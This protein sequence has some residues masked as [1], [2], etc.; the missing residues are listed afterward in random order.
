MKS[1]SASRDS[2][3][4][5]LGPLPEETEPFLEGLEGGRSQQEGR[6]RFHRGSYGGRE[7]IVVCSG[8]GKVNAAVASQLLI[9]RFGVGSLLLSGIG[10]A[11]YPEARPGDAV[12]RTE[13]IHHDVGFLYGKEELISYGVRV[14]PPPGR[15]GLLS[16]PGHRLPRG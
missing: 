6:F 2:P 12:I 13:L 3:I 11:L 9:D 15:G 10:G 4:G 8:A 14:W 1:M 7:V 5:I 16:L